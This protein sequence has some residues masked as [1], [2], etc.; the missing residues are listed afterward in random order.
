VS[1]AAGFDYTNRVVTVTNATAGATLALTATAADGTTTVATAMA[2]ENGEATFDIATTAGTAYS[3]TVA[4]GDD[5]VAAGGFFT[6]GWNAG[7]SWFSASASTGVSVVSGGDWSMPPSISNGIYVI[8]GTADF[9]LF[10]AMVATGSN[11]LVCV[12]FKYSFDSFCDAESL[13]S[14]DAEAIGGFAAA[15][16]MGTGVEMW[17]AYGYGGWVQLYGDVEPEEG[18]D[19]LVRAEADLSVNPPRVHYAVSADAGETFSPL[20]TNEARTA[21]WVM[22]MTTGAA[23]TRIDFDGLGNV[24]SLCGSLANANVAEA[25]GIGY[26]S[27]ADALAAATNSLVLLT[28]T[29]W[30]TNTP[31]GTVSVARGDFALAGVTLDG[32]GNVVVASGFSSI[33]NVGRINISLAQVA[34]LGVDTSGKSPA[35]IAEALAANGE[36]GIPLWES[37]VLG[38]D[39][40]DATAKPKASI[41]MNGDN[42]ELVLVG[43]DV[44][45]SAGATVTYKVYKSADL[46]DLEN[47]QPIEGEHAFDELTALPKSVSEPKMFYRLKL[48]VNGY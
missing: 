9:A 44:N 26:E 7:G 39:S 46:A 40:G 38:L 27:L 6:G 42:V 10:P 32:D 28:N 48:D 25:D 8:D 29:T 22:G 43:I 20:F 37:Y 3:Y 41:V 34:A 47:V 14:E 30:P 12:D 21:R 24:A 36:N 35:Q 19:Y 33:P 45:K 5:T 4:Q 16:G 2:D 23:I 11:R 17:M 15:D 31:V 13:S 1:D 18:R